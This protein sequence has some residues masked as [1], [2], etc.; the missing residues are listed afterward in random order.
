M[1]FCLRPT[2][3]FA[4]INLHGHQ[5]IRYFGRRSVLIDKNYAKLY[6]PDNKWPMK[7]LYDKK[8]IESSE[9]YAKLFLCDN[10]GSYILNFFF[11]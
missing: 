2:F 8:I 10:K 4:E 5:V 7:V 9:N 3:L 11:K 6:L 1:I